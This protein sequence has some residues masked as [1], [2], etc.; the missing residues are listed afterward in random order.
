M[1]K[2]IT[3][4]SIFWEMDI[5]FGDNWEWYSNLLTLFVSGI[6]V[7]DI[8]VEMREGQYTLEFQYTDHI[9]Y[10]LNYDNE[11]DLKEALWRNMKLI[12]AQMMQPM[13]WVYMLADGRN[14]IS[15]QEQLKQWQEA[16]EK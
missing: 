4:A 1:K 12:E 11:H 8:N 10:T 2:D 13:G 16:L 7:V 6:Q 3:R 15:R 9:S 14:A 5:D